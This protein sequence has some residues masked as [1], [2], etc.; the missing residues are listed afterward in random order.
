MKFHW[1]TE[2]FSWICLCG[3]WLLAAWAWQRVPERMPVHWNAAGEVDGYGGKFVGLLLL[4]LTAAGLYLLLLVLPKLDPGKLNYEGF[5]KVYTIIRS[6]LMAFLS[7]LYL[8]T[9]MAALGWR[10][11]MARVISLA[12]GP[13]FMV[14][15]NYLGKVRPNWFVGVRTPW[16]LS[17][18]LSWSKTHRLAGW[19]F[20]GSGLATLAAGLVRPQWGVFVL[21]GTMLPSVLAMM[22]YSYLVWRDDPNRIAPA[23]TS[24]ISEGADSV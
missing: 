1:R 22:V 12:M 23:G 3:I 15:G 14:L 18:K 21:M 10:V 8:A 7:V 4:P 17:S 11:D 24:P 9:T 19:L 16:T 2:L 5:A 13:M 20:M 6:T